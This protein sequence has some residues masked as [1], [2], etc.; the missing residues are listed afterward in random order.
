MESS[1]AEA[2]EI[3]N[4]ERMWLKKLYLCLFF[5]T[6]TVFAQTSDQMFGTFII[7]N[8]PDRNLI[9]PYFLTIERITD[10]SALIV[11]VGY[12]SR[13]IDRSRFFVG[14]IGD[15]GIIFSDRFGTEYKL[16]WDIHS[17]QVELR[18]DGIPEFPGL[19]FR[20]ITNEDIS[21]LIDND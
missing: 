8:G 5:I 2:M 3:I 17:G 15:D 6:G 19:S 20:Q 9:R 10:L 4:I 18:T 16:V 12:S 1:T 14:S 13:D 11:E 21:L 7:D